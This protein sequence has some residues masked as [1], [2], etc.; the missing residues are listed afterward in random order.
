MSTDEQ[1]SRAGGSVPQAYRNALFWRWVPA[2]PKALP[3][4]FVTLLYALG[5]AADA[6]GRLKFRDGRPI[7]LAQITAAARADEKD[8][9]R[10]LAAAEAAGVLGV[11]GQRK[12]GKITL[13]ALLLTPAP[14]WGAAVAC[15]DA[16][17]RKRSR[18]APFWPEQ[19]S[20]DPSPE[21]RDAKSG[22]PSPQV[23]PEPANEPRGAVPQSTSGDAATHYLGGRAPQGTQGNAK[24]LPQDVAEVGE[25]P[26]VA[27]A[28][29]LQDITQIEDDDSRSEVIRCSVC[30]GPL[31]TRRGR[32]TV[33]A[34]CQTPHLDSA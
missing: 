17:K 15:L 19:K 26:S 20:G 22:G 25:Q 32:A 9:R 27:A 5:S 23:E 31:I 29:G 8:V 33:H 4:A 13:Y 30:F 2:M 10:Y 14:D 28:T 34:H 11:I 3:S 12:P 18:P 7:R 21:V 1:D 6:S 16:T 24:E